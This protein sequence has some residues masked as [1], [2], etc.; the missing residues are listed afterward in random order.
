MK[1]FKGTKGAWKVVRNGFW[2]MGVQDSNGNWLTY[3]AGEDLMGQE[4][5]EANA[6]LMAASP[7]LLKALQKMVAMMDSGDEHGDGS[8]WH[9][10]ARKAI[11]K[12]LA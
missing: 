5:V 7:D 4:M 12:A 8:D 9:I 1:E 10:S 11:A 6:K 3:K 2:K